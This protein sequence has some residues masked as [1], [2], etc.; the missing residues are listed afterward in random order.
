M[1][2]RFGRVR[3]LLNSLSKGERFGSF[4]RRLGNAPL[5]TI[6]FATSTSLLMYQNCS[7]AMPTSS[8]TG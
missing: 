4:G 6:L 5:M 2:Q 8:S 7:P 1:K 3:D